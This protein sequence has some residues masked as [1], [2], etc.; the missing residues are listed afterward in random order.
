MLLLWRKIYKP[1]DEVIQ[2]NVIFA[3]NKVTRVNEIYL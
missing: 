3:S 1:G 2:R